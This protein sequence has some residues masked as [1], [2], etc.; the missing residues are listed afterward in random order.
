MLN[1]GK[2]LTLEQVDKMDAD[3]QAL[4]KTLKTIFPDR[5]KNGKCVNLE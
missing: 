3:W 1:G 2:I 4:K 5:Y